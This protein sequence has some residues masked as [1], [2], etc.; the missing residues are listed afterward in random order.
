MLKSL[1]LARLVN[2]G[3]MA[4]LLTYLMWSIGGDISHPVALWFIT[5]PIVA[6]LGGNARFG[7]AVLA[8]T[9]V[10][11]GGFEACRWMGVPMR[12]RPSPTCGCS[13]WPARSG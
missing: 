10:L 4:G 13:G 11:L 7:G 8:M 1:F 9:L 3:V 2:V 6:T 5:L 12:T